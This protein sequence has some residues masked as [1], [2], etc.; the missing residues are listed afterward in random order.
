MKRTIALLLI[1]A[2]LVLTAASEDQQSYE[3]LVGPSDSR[4]RMGLFT[5]YLTRYCGWN[6]ATSMPAACTA[7]AN[8]NGA[9][10]FDEMYDSVAAKLASQGQTVRRWPESA[11]WFGV[12]RD[13]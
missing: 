12:L 11:G 6:G 4:V 9:V 10:T 2:L 1:A 8:G 5:Y 3:A 13:P 7:D